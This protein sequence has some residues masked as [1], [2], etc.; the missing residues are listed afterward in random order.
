VVVSSPPG[1]DGVLTVNERGTA[2]YNQRL[3]SA[4]AVNRMRAD[5]PPEDLSQRAP[6]SQRKD[7]LA[8]TPHVHA[9]YNGLSWRIR[10]QAM[11]K[12]K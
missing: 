12:P 6:R 8:A 1:F 3:A 5:I 2:Q 11:E 10:K 7:G 9:E 4:R